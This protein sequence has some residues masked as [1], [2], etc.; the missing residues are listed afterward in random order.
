[1]K[2]FKVALFILFIIPVT[3]FVLSAVMV[4]FVR[5]ETDTVSATV[6]VGTVSVSLTPASFSYG[7]MVASESKESFDIIDISG[8]FNIE[9]EVGNIY[10][11]LT[12]QGA[13][14]TTDG[15]TPW[16][17]AAT[18]GSDIYV[19]EYATATN[20]TTRPSGYAPLNN[21]SYL[22]LSPDVSPLGS[23]FFGLKITTPSSF[24]VQDQQTAAVTVMASQAT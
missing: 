5:A 9:A 6:T 13:D 21:S 23:I 11:D 7:N 12:I 2:K 20:G 4:R 16:T 10:T 19:H 1:M 24:S 22:T 3:A 8:V 17:L 14:T 15:T 18:I